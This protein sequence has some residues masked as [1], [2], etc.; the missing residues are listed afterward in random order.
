MK[1]KI[2]IFLHTIYIYIYTIY[3][4]HDWVRMIE[5]CVAFCLEYEHFVCLFTYLFFAKIKSK[6]KVLY[7]W[8]NYF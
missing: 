7:T 3:L 8:I 4:V 2:L 1:D 5:V 6:Y